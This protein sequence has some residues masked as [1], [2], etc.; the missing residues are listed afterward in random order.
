MIMFFACASGDYKELIPLYKYCVNR[1]YPKQEVVTFDVEN[2]ALKRFL[3][4]P[5]KSSGEYIHVTDVD[6][7]ILPQEKTHEEYYTGHAHM[8]ACYL[9]GV[10]KSKNGIWE[11]IRR[12]VAGGEV[13]FL[14]EYYQRTKILRQR[15]LDEP[16]PPIREIDEIVLCRIMKHAGYPIPDVYTFPDGEPWD[17][18]Y[19]DLHL[20]DFRGKKYRKW[21]PDKNKVRD[22]VN[23]PEFCSIYKTLSLKWR[24]LIERVVLYS[25]ECD[26]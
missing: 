1:V 26:Q 12:R 15:F 6:I 7:L 22:L 8:G 5:T 4:N 16:V 21:K 24:E 20:G 2:P 25:Q 11:G 13:G 10:K 14:P 18:N 23:E 17:T 3:V 19:R 9:G